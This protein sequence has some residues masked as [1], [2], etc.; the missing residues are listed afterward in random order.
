MPV[1][2]VT[3]D[4]SPKRLDVTEQPLYSYHN[5]IEQRLDDAVK[6]HGLTCRGD[7][8]RRIIVSDELIES[9]KSDL[10]SYLKTDIERVLGVQY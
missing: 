3:I 9:A 10:E 1:S 4:S 2:Y 5:A 6:P 7:G 8:M